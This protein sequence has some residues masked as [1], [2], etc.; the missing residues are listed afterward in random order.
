MTGLELVHVTGDR[1][2]LISAGLDQRVKLWDV[3]VDKLQRGV[4]GIAVRRQHDIPTAVAD[5]SSVDLCRLE[6]GG[7][8]M[9]VCGVGMD[10]WRL[11]DSRGQEAIDDG[12]NV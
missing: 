5:V 3:R 10:V 9:L 6:D 2:S 8:G 4:H 11:P 1:Y 12:I 7:I